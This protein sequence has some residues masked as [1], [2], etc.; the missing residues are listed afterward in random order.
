MLQLHQHLEDNLLWKVLVDTSEDLLLLEKRNL[1]TLQASFDVWDWKKQEF[2]LKNMRLWEDWWLSPVWIYKGM[3]VFSFYEPEGSPLGKGVLVFDVLQKNIL[4]QNLELNFFGA[5]AQQECLLL[6]KNIESAQTK[7]YELKTGKELVSQILAK[8]ENLWGY[9]MANIYPIENPFYQD[10]R[11]FIH[12]KT[13]KETH[14][15]IQYAETKTHIC[16]GYGIELVEKF[17]YFLLITDIAGNIELS[18]EISKEQSTC[19]AIY[20]DY[21]LVFH[22]KVFY[23][24]SLKNKTL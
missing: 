16:I 7:A 18:Q 21:L 2:V 1:H 5:T 17:A 20:K 14:L 23:M 4:W 12:Q 8:E 9:R 19:L 6:R 22:S 24:Y 15:P 11:K 13:Q 3:I 10:L